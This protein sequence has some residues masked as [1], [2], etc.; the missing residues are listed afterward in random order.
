MIVMTVSDVAQVRKSYRTVVGGRLEGRGYVD[1]PL[2][3]K[4]S[5]TEFQCISQSE[6]GNHGW[7]STLDLY[8]HTGETC[9]LGCTHTSASAEALWF[10]THTRHHTL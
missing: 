8:P 9:P 7:V 5:L 10:K 4:P 6:S 1:I 2:D 3:G